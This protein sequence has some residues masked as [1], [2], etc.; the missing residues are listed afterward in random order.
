MS[1][2][3]KECRSGQKNIFPNVY[4]DKTFPK[5]KIIVEI[6]SD[7]EDLAV[8]L[9]VKKLNE[10]RN[11]YKGYIFIPLSTQRDEINLVDKRWWRFTFTYILVPY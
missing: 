3:V 1:M 8:K 5:I 7:E 2:A 6:D 9:E 4:V 10:L 11:E